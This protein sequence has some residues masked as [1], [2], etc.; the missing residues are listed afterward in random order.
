MKTKHIL[1]GFALL[2]LT[3]CIGDLDVKPLDPNINTAEKVYRIKENYYKNLLKIYSLLAISGQDG[4]GSSDLEGLDAGNTQFYRSLWNLQVASTDECINSWGDP[5]VPEIMEM[6]WTPVGNEAIEGTYHRAMLMVAFANEYLLQTSDGNMSDRGIDA[7]FWPTVHQY[8]NEAR[9]LRALAYYYLMDIYGNPPFI[10]ETSYSSAPSQIGRKAL[11]EWIEGELLAIKDK[12]GAAKSG[13]YGRVDQG[14]VNALLSRMYLNAEVYTGEARYDDCVTASKA[15]IDAGVYDLTTNYGDLFKADNDRPEVTKEIIFPIVFEGTKTQT[16]GGIRFLICAS[17]GASEVSETTDGMKGGWSG[18]RALPNLVN[19]FDFQNSQAPKASE[20]KDK[21]GI[22]YDAN[23]SIDITSGYIKTFETEGWAVYKYFN[24]TSEGVPG[25]NLDSPDTDIPLIRLPEIYLN[26]AEAV[27]R[28]A[29]NGNKTD[30]V[31]YINDLRR[32]GFGDN[33]SNIEA[34]DLTVDFL[35]D[36]RG[37]ELYWE[38]TRRTDLVRYGKYTSGSYLWQ[39]KGGV[40]NG[41]GVEEFRN[42]FP[43]PSSDMT[44]NG[45]LKQNPGY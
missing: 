34:N 38:G 23:R 40:K 43:I 20:I 5:W 19:L 24:V 4:V 27:V 3:S 35:L 6:K 28:G 22:F 16:Y 12:V 21:R 25:S 29:T 14:V 17:R 2:L 8:R 7:D 32:R 31:N 9:F 37:R 33:L 41:T 45:S 26:Y 1:L 44:V 10:T 13:T 18:N 42:I 36:E 39:Y 30:A 15:V 11:F